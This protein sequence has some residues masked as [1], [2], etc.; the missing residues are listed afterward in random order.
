VCS[1]ISPPL[2]SGE[3]GELYE[4]IDAWSRDP[5]MPRRAQERRERFLPRDAIACLAVASPWVASLRL[6]D[7]FN[8]P[9]RR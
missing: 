7:H 5:D 9:L 2:N 6:L 4:L 1:C 8:G 3:C